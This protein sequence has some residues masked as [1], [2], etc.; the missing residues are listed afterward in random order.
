MNS[1]KVFLW[2]VFT[3]VQNQNKAWYEGLAKSL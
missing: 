1:K 3:L 2:D